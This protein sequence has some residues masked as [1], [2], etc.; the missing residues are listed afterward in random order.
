MSYAL[1]TGASKGIGKAIAVELASRKINLL[2]VARSSK[3]LAGLATQLSEKFGIL[4]DWFRADLADPSAPAA[5]LTWVTQKDYTVSI[6]VNNA[7]YGLSGSFDQY[8]PEEHIAM[9][10]VNMHAPVVLSHLFLPQLK[11]LPE[12]YI[13]NVVSSAAYQAVPGLGVYGA[14]KAFLLSFSRALHYELKNSSVCVTAVSPGSTDTNFANRAKV[15]Q[16]ALKAAEKVN[17]SP[18]EVAKIAV[19]A[20]FER[21]TEVITGLIN[22]VG[23]FLVWLLPK[24]FVENAAASLYELH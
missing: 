19:E 3:D 8:S 22:K 13:L 17:M 18:E 4:T 24:K 20:M 21:K 5:I 6:L 12:S 16:K 23:A 2:L 7:G 10:Q 11:K 14:S 15:G 1:I 9:M